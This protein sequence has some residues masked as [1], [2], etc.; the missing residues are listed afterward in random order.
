ME[1]IHEFRQRMSHRHISTCTYYINIKAGKD[2]FHFLHLYERLLKRWECCKEATL[3]LGGLTSTSSRIERGSKLRRLIC[4]LKNHGF[5]TFRLIDYTDPY[6]IEYACFML[7]KPPPLPQ[8]QA[9]TTPLQP[10]VC[11]FIFVFVSIFLPHFRCGLLPYSP[12]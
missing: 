8:W 7:S 2:L 1:C 4:I 5:L 9:L 12:L 10:P 11:I 6:D 3:T